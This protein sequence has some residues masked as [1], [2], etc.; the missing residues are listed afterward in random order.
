MITGIE[1]NQP[2]RINRIARGECLLSIS[3]LVSNNIQ[4]IEKCMESIRP[5]LEQVPS[6][7]IIVD[8]VG[9]EK[10]D[11]SLAIA[12]EYADKIVHFEWCDDFAAA[13]NAGL[14]ECQGQWF[15]YFDD[16][17]YFDNVTALIDF[18]SDESKY[19]YYRAVEIQGRDYIDYTGNKYNLRKSLRLFRLV[20]GAT[21]QGKIHEYFVPTTVPMYE[22]SVFVHHFGYVHVLD[23]TNRNE[24][25]LEKEVE[26]DCLNFAAWLQMI[27]ALPGSQLIKKIQLSEQA[28]VAFDSQQFSDLAFFQQ[29]ALIDIIV[30]LAEFYQKSGNIPQSTVVLE[31]YHY[32]LK[33]NQFFEGLETYIRFINQLTLCNYSKAIDYFIRIQEIIQYYQKNMQEY[34]EIYTPMHMEYLSKESLKYCFKL[35]IATLES[36]YNYALLC[37]IYKK[38]DFKLI[39]YLEQ[40]TILSFIKAS[41]SEKNQGVFLS[42]HKLCVEKNIEIEFIQLCQ[43]IQFDLKKEEK[44]QLSKWLSEIQSE[45]CYFVYQKYKIN[46]KACFEKLKATVQ[47]YEP[48]IEEYLITLIQ[49]EISPYYILKTANQNE[50]DT[51]CYF[52]DRY[53][54]Q[55]FHS[56]NQFI[57]S[58]AETMQDT[59]VGNYLVYQLLKLIVLNPSTT[60]NELNQYVDSYLNYGQQLVIQLY[61]EKVF[62]EE[63]MLLPAEY[64]WLALLEQALQCKENQQY[65]EYIQLL[66]EGLMIYP[67]SKELVNKLLAS[68]EQDLRKQQ[69]IEDELSRLASRVKQDILKLISEGNLTEAKV[70]Y[71]ELV[72]ITPN[73]ENLKIIQNLLK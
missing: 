7:L 66:K 73:D 56:K 2:G 40:K 24:S 13:R 67:E 48:G 60:T 62:I 46:N 18:F 70:L 33:K 12:R 25:L 71:Q 29:K 14:R 22:T 72:E 39:D 5:L 19:N 21:F 9:E 52:I 61:N 35:L 63:T 49:K 23:K 10:S 37:S 68:A 50:L 55:D 6:E 45:S 1:I 20:E 32:L 64:H 59:V 8:T 15:M 58:L 28:L 69:S 27:I 51:F 44:L 42:L 57:F 16:D 26:K 4:T 31:K 36:S 65:I 43:T 17:E 3:L 41:I 11:G 38:I 30:F 54:S 53:F 34:F 47:N